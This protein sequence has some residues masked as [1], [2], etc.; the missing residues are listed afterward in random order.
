MPNSLG[1]DISKWQGDVDFNTFSKNS[2]FVICKATE[3]TGYID[4]KL[5]RNRDEARR[6]GMGLGFYHFA[7]P[8]L[9]A[10]AEDE[11]NYFLKA[12]GVLKEGEILI[13]DYE[14]STVGKPEMQ[15]HVNWCKKWL[16]YIKSKTGVAP[17]MYLNQ[18]QVKKL[19]WKIVVDAG[20]GLWIAA[21]TYDPNNN[22]FN[23]G[24]WPFAAMQQWTNQQRVPGVTGNVDGNVFFGDMATF[25]KYGYKPQPNPTP[26]PSPITD[27][28]I[29]PANLLT[30]ENFKPN[31]DMEVQAIRSTLND[32]S[33]D[34]KAAKAKVESGKKEAQETVNALN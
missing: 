12:I 10:N 24:Q 9:N 30:S 5:A 22:N 16:D 6:T 20:Y 23:K 3:G 34:L 8:D 31:G 32:L 14:P 17:L 13:L 15:P 25:K 26:T 11:A 28:T 27:Q 29:I 21:Y 7:R 4:P 18:S 19:D 33:R 2:L 1:N